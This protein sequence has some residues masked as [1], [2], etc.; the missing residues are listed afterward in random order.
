[1]FND[2][3]LFKTVAFQNNSQSTWR[4]SSL[5][6]R[7]PSLERGFREGRS[8]PGGC[9]E[10]KEDLLSKRLSANKARKQNK[11]SHDDQQPS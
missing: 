5:E 2:C 11:T 6:E 9:A 8:A 1:M 4:T 10:G 3:S 7:G